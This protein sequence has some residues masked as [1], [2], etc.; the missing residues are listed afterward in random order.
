VSTPGSGGPQPPE[1]DPSQPGQ[2]AGWGQQPPAGQP[3][4]GQQPTG[5][6]YAGQPGQ[7]YPGQQPPAGQSWGAP[8]QPGYPQQPGFGQPGYPQ[9][10]YPQQPGT[11]QPFGATG[12]QAFGA[13]APQKPKR[14]WLPIVGGVIA[15]IVVLS[16]LTNVLGGGDPKVGDCIQ[17]T[18]DSDFETVDCDSS[19]A[20]R[21]VVGIDDDMTGD[22][23]RDAP[24]EQLCTDFPDTT[25]VLWSGSDESED[26]HV[27]CTTDV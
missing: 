15:L 5:E 25:F 14:K 10:G 18:G 7:P 9:P 12:A 17:Q 22:E 3:Y 23:F 27:Y 8:Q 24:A 11:P 1:Q 26:G 19:D 2:P 20:E 6:P 13:P 16:V 21:K 4:P